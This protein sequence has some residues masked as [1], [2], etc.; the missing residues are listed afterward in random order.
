MMTTTRH[1]LRR[2]ALWV[3]CLLLIMTAG[4][5]GTAGAARAQGE[6][7]VSPP[8]GSLNLS[9]AFSVSGITPGHAIAIVLFDGAGNRF[10]YQ[11]DG[12][13]QAIVVDGNGVASLSV[14]P[15]T[16]LPGAVA[17]AWRAVF[18]EEETGYVATIPF[19]VGS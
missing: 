15:A 10:T 18:T 1:H 7:T 12:V 8:S 14:T 11:Q 13:D 3:A 5:V 19:D 17:G 4:A 2:V 16:D 6:A 9:F